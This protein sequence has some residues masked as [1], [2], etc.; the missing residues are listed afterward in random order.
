MRNAGSS[1]AEVITKKFPKNRKILIVCGSGNKAGDAIHAAEHLKRS[2]ELKFFFVKGKAHIKNAEAAKMI[3][4][5]KPEIISAKNLKRAISESNLIVDA[6]L[7]TGMIGEPSKEY[8]EVIEMINSSGKPVVSID[9]PSGIGTGM[10]INPTVT[11]ALHAV[12]Q[13]CTTKNS[14]ELIVKDIGITREI[15]LMCGPGEIL[16]YPLPASSS[17]K[18]MNGV[19]AVIA[20]LSFPGAGIVSSLAAEKTGLDLLRFYTSDI[21]VG[22]AVHYSP[23]IIPHALQTDKLVDQITGADAVLI[24]PGLGLDKSRADLLSRVLSMDLPTVIDADGLKLLPQVKYH[25]TRPLVLTP[26]SKEFLTMTGMQADDENILKYAQKTS[27][28]VIVKG[29]IDRI[30]DGKD[31]YRTSGGNARMTMGGTGDLLAGIIAALVAKHMDPLQA[32]KLGS[33]INKK[34]GEFCFDKFSYWYTIMDMVDEIPATMKWC[35]EFATGK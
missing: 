1:V 9:V 21:F 35:Y 2:Y 33:F 8:S 7:G 16:R 13:P 29:E 22:S 17:H 23:F 6:L 18:G 34:C 4:E 20:G 5:M 11:V 30:S 14:G 15:E 27:S 32:V 25:R 19:L 24:G 28:I 3:G 12:K 26:H 31:I 10:Q